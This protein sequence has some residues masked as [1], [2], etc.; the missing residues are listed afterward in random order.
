MILV[1]SRGFA[2][3]R[4]LVW[5]LLL[6]LVVI[7]G[8]FFSYVR[9]ADPAGYY[10]VDPLASGSLASIPTPEPL[11]QKRYQV[12]QQARLQASDKQILFGDT[13][14]HTTW[15]LDAFMF[16]LPIM[17]GSKGA[18]PPAAA[19]DYARYI[20]QLDFFFL[21]D[22]A[23][24]YTPQRWR[25]AQD[26]VR[27]CN[28]LSGDKQNPDL[29]A[30]LGFEWSQMGNTPDEHYGHHNVLFKDTSADLLP[31][32]PI[33]ASGL[34]EL[35]LR[36]GSGAQGM[37]SALQWLDHGNRNYYQ[38]MLKFFDQLREVPDCDP[39]L[40]SPE[41]P[42]DCYESA[43]TPGD[44][45]RKLD[46][47]GFDTLVVPHGSSWGIYTPPGASWDHQL[48]A[49]Y[50]DEDKGRLIEVY[51]GHGNSENYR[52]FEARAYDADGNVYCPSPQLNYL[53]SCWQAGE[54]IRKRCQKSG[55]Q[56][57]EC[58]S[59]AKKARQHFL[60]VENVSGWMSVPG[61]RDQEWLDAGQA[62]DVF[63]PAFNY[64]PKKSVQYGLALRNF[65]DPDKPLRF[66][67]G[68][69]GSSDSHFARP[70]NGFK[71]TPRI[72]AGDAG[73]RGGR[74]PFWQWMIYDR[75]REKPAAHSRSLLELDKYR[76]SG[77]SEQERKMSFLTAGG[78]VAVHAQGRNRDAIWDAMKRKEVYG[79]SGH[80]ILLW[81]DLLNGR[82]DQKLLPMGSEVNLARDPQFS[83]TAIGSFKQ[84]PGCP[85]YVQQAL[86]ERKL[87]KLAGGECYHPS[88]ERY[89]IDRIEVIRVRPQ[90]YQDEPVDELI[91]DSW[92]VF[93]CEPDPAGCS[94]EFTDAE[95]MSGG[96]D[97]LYYVRAIEEPTPMINGDNLRAQ[98]NNRGEVESTHPCY[99]DTR[100]A[101][102]DDCLALKGQRAWSSPIFVNSVSLRNRISQRN[103][104]SHGVSDESE[105]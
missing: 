49:K 32:R 33:G 23:E 50:H 20:S 59:R 24:S 54:I 25:Q 36:S 55:E 85:D 70:G 45:Y 80:R 53:P 64:V 27:R 17:N 15:S 79:T 100:T 88:D 105:R 3:S 42:T 58:E 86:S 69:I 35:G 46:E 92:R 16:S 39:N 11:L 99:G 63:A 90:N 102:D 51:S 66:T 34:A 68:F 75:T 47:W 78:V 60:E 8:L 6:S 37:A 12:Q 82:D 72:G 52:S 96:R 14:V 7:A 61:S 56:V 89:L 40:P 83:V 48:K 30:F 21:A 4:V 76:D 9:I 74:T 93:E 73:M 44:L 19:C 97:A 71:Q 1:H 38:S 103:N 65:D 2:L 13:H 18:Y 57:E 67:W 28:A 43:A 101:K 94:V 31:A 84:K 26:A 77:V 87:E 10:Q 5:I 81:F 95:F 29:V 41:L 104:A 98:F 91:E 62:R 22:H